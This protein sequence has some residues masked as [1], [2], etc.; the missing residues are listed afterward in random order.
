ME[1]ALAE[2]QSEGKPLLVVSSEG[3]DHKDDAY[4]HIAGLAAAV[5][6]VGAENVQLSMELP[7]N[8]FERIGQHIELRVDKTF[9]LNDP[10]VG[11]PMTRALGY[12]LGQEIDVHRTD[13]DRPWWL[14]PDP[15]QYLHPF[16]TDGEIVSIN[17]I[18]H[19][20]PNTKIVFHVGGAHHLFTLAGYQTHDRLNDYSII[21]ELPRG[22]PFGSAY[23]KVLMF[24]NS[25][26]NCENET[27]INCDFAAAHANA[28]QIRNPGE[29]D[30]DDRSY[31][32]IV[33]RIEAAA[34]NYRP[35]QENTAPEATSAASPQTTNKPF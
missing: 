9:N 13:T 34:E 20:N 33:A 28:I 26:Q 22:E 6:L 25:E 11:S 14:F 35:A 2:A 24:N 8:I 21:D 7:P 31:H 17:Q 19:E 1:A 27:T 23:G 3:H 4:S 30:A 32:T 29:M 16:R 10:T 12:A 5:E 15:N 18:P